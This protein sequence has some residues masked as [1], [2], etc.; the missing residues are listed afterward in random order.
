MASFATAA[1]D[2]KGKRPMAPEEEEEEAAAAGEAVE[3]EEV[4]KLLLVSDDG[5]EFRVPAASARLSKILS[6][7]I[8]EGCADGRIPVSGVHSDVLAMLVEYCDKHAPHY[9]PNASARHRY[10][11]PPFPVDLSPSASSI[12][13]V[14]FINPNADPH[15]LNAFDKKFLDVDNSTLFE[16]I[17]AADFLVIEDLLDDA[18]NAVA[19]KMRRKTAEEIRDVFDIENDYTPEQE[20]EVR[21]ENAWAFED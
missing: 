1:E 3:E 4:Q 11:F 9:D 21:R 6:G 20:A 17:M 2:R 19:D 8:E 18:C 10:P 13:P 14:T 12:S 7:M 16:I 5:V 15:G